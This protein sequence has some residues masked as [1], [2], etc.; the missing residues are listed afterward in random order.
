VV[1]DVRDVLSTG[2]FCPN[3]ESEEIS[4]ALKWATQQ[5]QRSPDA[6]RALAMEHLQ[7]SGSVSPDRFK[8]KVGVM[9]P[10]DEVERFYHYR[11]AKT[12]RAFVAYRKHQ[13]EA[14][15]SNDASLTDRFAH[16]HD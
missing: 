12:L 5:E 16:H 2:Q 9:A 11:L 13:L 1:S 6:L 10:E 15:G 7:R 3:R 14:N 8:P 4:T